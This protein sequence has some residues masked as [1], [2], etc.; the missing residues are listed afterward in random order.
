LRFKVNTTE[1]GNV[2]SSRKVIQNPDINKNV[3]SGFY[4]KNTLKPVNDMLEPY[5]P[6]GMTI[7]GEVVGYVDGTSTFL[8]KGHDYGCKVGEWK[9][10]PY[11]ITVTDD[12]GV[13]KEWNINDVYDWTIS[14]IQEH[15]EFA[16]NIMPLEILYHGKFCDLYPEL[17]VS[18]ESWY[19]EVLERMKNEKKWCMEEKEPLCHL[20]DDEIEKIK[21]RL[22][23]TKKDSDNNKKL[24]KELERLIESEAPRE[25]VVIRIDNDIFPRAWKLKTNLHEMLSKKSHDKGE[26]DIEELDGIGVE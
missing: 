6:N 12:N 25:G 14:F 21:K 19:D 22:K 9:F 18:S 5:I 20:F 8:Q 1:Y 7:Y 15:P 4:G 11:R 17:D 2:Y 24:T 23:K 13:K 10:M 26:I 16:N 3:T